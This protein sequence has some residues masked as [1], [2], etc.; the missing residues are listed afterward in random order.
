MN[1]KLK[2]PLTAVFS[3]LL[4]G[5][6]F[7]PWGTNDRVTINKIKEPTSAFI[8]D[9]SEDNKKQSNS[10]MLLSKKIITKV[11]YNFSI[12]DLEIS[13]L[14]IKKQLKKFK[15]SKNDTEI[16]KEKIEKNTLLVIAENS[17]E[18]TVTVIAENEFSTDDLTISNLAIRKQLKSFNRITNDSEIN[19]EKTGEKTQ[20]VIAENSNE[21]TPIVITEN[22]IST[23]DLIASNLAIK[24]QLKSFNVITNDTEIA[25]E[26]TQLVIS[27][28]ISELTPTAITENRFSSDDL[29]SS[30]LASIKQLK[31]IDSINSEDNVEFSSEKTDEEDYVDFENENKIIKFDDHFSPEELAI[32]NLAIQK[33]LS[34]YLVVDDIDEFEIPEKPETYPFIEDVSDRADEKNV[35]KKAET[36]KIK[37]TNVVVKNQELIFSEAELKIS[38]LAIQK[39]LRSY[40]DA[41]NKN[42]EITKNEANLDKIST[43]PEIESDYE[44]E[45]DLLIS[46]SAHKEDSKRAPDKN[47]SKRKNYKNQL[48]TIDENNLLDD[49]TLQEEDDD[50]YGS[51]RIEFINNPRYFTDSFDK[52]AVITV[53]KNIETPNIENVDKN[54]NSEIKSENA[55]TEVE[56]IE[57]IEVIEEIEINDDGE[58]VISSADKL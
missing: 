5:V 6:V 25:K 18:L 55:L 30:D 10:E 53:E 36:K 52:K 29:R 40:N 54:L 38:N 39:Q 32:S 22:Q 13:N 33:Q 34:R 20:L 37:N 4:G 51:E 9:Q 17:N 46:N 8:F 42:K 14:A 27:E 24:K 23:N 2:L 47:N 35:T 16:A 31:S 49:D 41:L 19:K 15:T 48:S 11:D 12:S 56:E 21:L 28:N 26:K 44:D 58:T 43:Q 3:F 50:E 45:S 1:D 7:F 57:E